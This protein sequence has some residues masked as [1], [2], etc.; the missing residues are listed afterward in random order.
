MRPA[1]VRGVIGNAFSANVAARHPAAS[2]AGMTRIEVV[3]I[4]VAAV[5]VFVAAFVLV[6]EMSHRRARSEARE[7]RARLNAMATRTTAYVS[8]EQGRS[9]GPFGPID[10]AD[11][12][13]A[14]GYGRPAG[15][16]PPP[17]WHDV[18]YDPR[19]GW[20]P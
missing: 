19:S 3:I 10:E 16:G 6:L 17:L 12:D 2:P 5:V 8:G 20:R 13:G 18:P 1:V 14:P 15:Y 9:P 7:R 11:Y 4:A